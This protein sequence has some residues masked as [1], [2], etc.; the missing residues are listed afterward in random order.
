VA[1][2]LYG[3]DLVGGSVGALFTS[4]VLAPVLGL[5]QTFVVVALIGGAGAV[6]SFSIKSR[7]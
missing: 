5:V 4:A 7:I 1:A 6:L 3:A 2:L